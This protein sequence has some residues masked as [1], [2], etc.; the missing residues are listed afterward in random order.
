MFLKSQNAVVVLLLQS[1][2]P[3]KPKYSTSNMIMHLT[4]CQTVLSEEWMLGGRGVRQKEGSEM[5]IF[6]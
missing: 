6:D 5:R 4:T 1:C 3:I 2:V